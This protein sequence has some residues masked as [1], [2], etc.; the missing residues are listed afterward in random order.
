[1][2]LPEISS[3]VALL[4]NSSP[5]VGPY[6]HSRLRA[7]IFGSSVVGGRKYTETSHP[8]EIQ[9]LLTTATRRQTN[10]APRR[11][12]R[13][14]RNLNVHRSV[15]GPFLYLHWAIG[16]SPFRRCMKE[17]TIDVVDHYNFTFIAQRNHLQNYF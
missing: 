12:C 2:F 9:C 16:Q 4:I 7:H 8:V 11:E 10:S 17:D 1:M 3:Q 14:W 15:L 13:I 6:S 5:L